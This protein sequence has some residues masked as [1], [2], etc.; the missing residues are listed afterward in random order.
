MFSPHVD[1]N[2]SGKVPMTGATMRIGAFSFSVSIPVAEADLAQEISDLYGL[3]P[4]V[5]AGELTDFAIT[6]TYP[7]LWRRFVGREIQ[8]S[9][10][11]VPTY[12]PW[13]PALGV[14]MLESAINWCMG[15][16]ITRFLLIH[17][18]VVERGGQALLLPGVSGAGK[19]TLCALL[20]SRG[21]RLLSDEIAMVRPADGSILP[22]PDG[23]Y[24]PRTTT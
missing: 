20:A 10:D 23:S 11:G 12:E 22:H 9:F 2:W 19:S 13:P 8:V 14:P 3:Y 5:G 17:A 16:D 4:Q 1:S 6:L 15:R 7:N 18:G 24:P 21:W